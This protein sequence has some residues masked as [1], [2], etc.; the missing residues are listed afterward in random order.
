M[1]GPRH[2]EIHLLDLLADPVRGLARLIRERLDF[3]GHNRKTAPELSGSRG[4]H[5]RVDGE[6]IRLPRDPGD[7]VCDAADLPRGRF[8]FS[9]P[10]GTCHKLFDD[11]SQIGPELTGAQRANLDYILDNVLDPSAISRRLAALK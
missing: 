4:F 10:S 3:V 7:R 9:K 5:T 11:G 2:R 8:L 1:R 6:E